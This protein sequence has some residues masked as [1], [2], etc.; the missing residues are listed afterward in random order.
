MSNHKRDGL[1]ENA[2]MVVDQAVAESLKKLQT[3]LSALSQD[4][5]EVIEEF[6]AGKTVQQ[7]GESRG[8]TASQAQDLVNKVKRDLTQQLRS[9]CKVRQ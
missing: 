1:D 8:I 9:L 2:T 4:S 6:F 7:I 5:Q 3:A